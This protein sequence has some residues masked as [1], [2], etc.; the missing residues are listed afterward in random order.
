M[1][2]TPWQTS[3]P[4][5][6]GPYPNPPRGGRR[7]L[8]AAVILPLGWAFLAVFLTAATTATLLTLRIR[9]D[10]YFYLVARVF[11]RV[12]LKLQGVDIRIDHGER[13]ATDH[14][15]I[16]IFNHASQLDVFCFTAIMPPRCT[17]IV[18]REM[19]WVPFI[20]LAV[21]A[22]RLQTINRK[23]LAAAKRSMAQVVDYMH[24]TKC[25]VLLSPE[26]T[27]AKSDELG[28]FKK[29]AF[30][31]AAETKAPLLPI[32]VRGARACLP[33]GRVLADPGLV[34]MEVL[35]EIDT[36]EFTAAQVGERAMELTKLF[37]QH[38]AG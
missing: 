3:M 16:L 29:G 33:M 23:D 8:R 21:F 26:G 14:S 12:V 32:V 19:L 25:S 13:I 7:L 37:Q 31:L 10:R 20:G 24:Q 17:I 15:Q 9:S 36:R 38:L 35:P 34:T 2:P 4:T 28:Q 27:R 18:K 6:P 22:Y 1:R 11:G 5:G 30:H